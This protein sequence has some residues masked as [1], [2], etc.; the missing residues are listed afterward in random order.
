MHVLTALPPGGSPELG[1]ASAGEADAAPP[2]PS[3][4]R[5]SPPPR[6]ASWQDSCGR[7]TATAIAGIHP[8]DV[9]PPRYADELFQERQL[10]SVTA[11]TC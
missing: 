7:S 6:P 11:N 5:P 4:M 8:S 9:P 3:R 10:R 1:C 2:E